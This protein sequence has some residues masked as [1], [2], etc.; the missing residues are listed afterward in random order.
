[1]YEKAID[2]ALKRSR[3]EQE[4]TAWDAYT[5]VHFE[6]LS[7]N[8]SPL[9]PPFRADLVTRERKEAWVKTGGLEAANAAAAPYLRPGASEMPPIRPRFIR[10]PTPLNDAPTSNQP[11]SG[12][13]PLLPY[14]NGEKDLEGSEAALFEVVVIP[15]NFT[16]DT[17]VQFWTNNLVDQELM[18]FIE[19]SLSQSARSAAYAQ[20]GVAMARITD[21]E[22]L[23]VTAEPYKADGD[24]ALVGTADLAETYIPLILAYA[25]LLMI[26]TVGGMLLTST[27]E[28]KSNKIIEVLLSSVSATQLMV[29]KLVGL[30]F[31]G[32]TIPALLLSL[33]F[34]GL[35][36]AGGSQLT[37]ALYT[38]LFSSPLIPL[39]F[40]Y[41]VVGYLLFASIYLAVGAMSNSIQ[42]AQ[43]FVG[44]L[45]I[46]L[47]LPVPFLQLVIQDPNGLIAKIFTWIPLYTPYAVMMRIS[48]DPP[49]WE[50]MGATLLLLCVVAY[51]VTTMGR[52]YRNGVLSSG[53]A[54]TLQQARSLA[55]KQ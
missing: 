50:I 39:F 48:A 49:L 9:K 6:N 2:A 17:P 3:L 11:V 25:L 23:S 1:R 32:M 22:A 55:R 21:I 24:G 26:T 18:R 33:G 37:D 51:V 40:F 16:A 15:E 46:L 53:G 34:A 42:D 54:P 7:G 43:S 41:F 4:I 27:I 29:G 8:L 19:R 35:F 10:V 13:G 45:T 52:I 44:P 36:L 28:E 47:V 14:L 20:E 38:V 12:V 31:V 30:A 5:A